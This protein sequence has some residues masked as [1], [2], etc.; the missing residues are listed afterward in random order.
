MKGAVAAMA[1]VCL[2]LARSGRRLA[3]DVIFAATAGEEVDSAG[4]RRLL[5]QGLPPIRS[6]IVGEP[7]RLHVATAHKG[8]LWLQIETHGK[9]AHGSMPE[10][11][12]NAIMA[13]QKVIAELSVFQ[14]VSS[15]HPSLGS[16][17]QNIGTIQGGV[18]PNIVPDRCT[19]TVDIRTLPGESHE[20]IVE[21]LKKRLHPASVRVLNSMTAVDTPVEYPFIQSALRLAQ[22]LHG[23]PSSPRGMSYYTDASVLYP[24]LQ[25]PVLIFG[26]GDERLAHQANETVDLNEVLAAAAFYFDLVQEVLHE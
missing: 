22:H 25:C 17:S 2:A 4:A 26:P 13:M 24:A 14:P 10:Q 7:T 23:E 6:I 19:L 20:S 1:M 18:K 15:P 8:A 11:G 21:L 12:Q 3:G 9:A 16:G 5:A